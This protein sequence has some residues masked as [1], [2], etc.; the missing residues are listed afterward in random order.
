VPDVPDG[1][2]FERRELIGF[3]LFGAAIA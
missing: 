2:P 1:A 3:V